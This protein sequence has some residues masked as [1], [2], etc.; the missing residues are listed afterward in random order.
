MASGLTTEVLVVG[1][2]LAGLAAAVA[3]TGQGARVRL[4]ERKP[5][6]G[7]RAY[8][9]AHPALE[10]VIDSQHV[11]LGCCTN[12]IDLCRLTGADR[13]IRWYDEISFLEPGTAGQPTRRS[14]LGPGLLPAPGHASLSF[15]R[16]H[17]LGWRDK[18]KIASG[19]LEFL[20]GYPASDEEPFSAWL[21]RTGQTE[22]AVR[23]FWEPVVVATLNDSFERCSTRYAGKVFHESFLRSG[24]GGRLGIPTQPLSEFYASAANWAEQRGAEV[25][26]RASAERLTWAAGVWTVTL[27]DGTSHSARQVVLALPFEAVARLLQTLPVESAERKLIE[28]KLASF[29]HAPIT[30][31]HLWFE[32]PVTDL[33]HAALLDT[34][35]QW[36]FNKTAIR[37]DEPAWR[38]PQGQYLELTISASFAELRG[39]REALVTDALRELASFFPAV[40]DVKLLKSAVLKEARATFSVAPG[41]DAVRP[42]S[43]VLE[44]GLYLAGDWTRTE[45]PSTMEG[46]V[47]SGRLAA[48]ALLAAAGTP[49]ELLTADL[50][51]SGLMRWLAS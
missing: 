45:W 4:L 5:Y 42:P 40:T 9:Y 15:L 21:T 7:G 12:L 2:G 17:M 41:L 11:L 49:R 22:R 19:L 47:R 33:D 20:R 30:T 39:G 18:A 13:H 28:P 8:S 25:C 14:D 35:I 16:V 37:R 24:E 46:A 1:A 38:T 26:L 44:S 23:H 3:L 10:E 29:Q 27:A 36:M 48:E 34:R 32:R 51:A 6:I 43:A 50:P 31:I